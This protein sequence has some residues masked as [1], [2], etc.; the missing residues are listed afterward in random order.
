[1]LPALGIYVTQVKGQQLTTSI[2]NEVEPACV[3]LARTVT[4]PGQKGRF[5]EGQ[6]EG[7]PGK[8]DHLLFEPKHKSL[9][10]LG[11]ANQES[12]AS[13][14]SLGQCGINSPQTLPRN[15]CQAKKGSGV[16]SV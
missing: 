9:E 16:G 6:I 2:E 12:V 1:M 5:V 4:I 7:D 11:L 3:N 8:V 10:H 15:A 13:H 14:C